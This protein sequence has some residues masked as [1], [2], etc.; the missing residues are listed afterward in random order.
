PFTERPRVH[1]R[2]GESETKHRPSCRIRRGFSQGIQVLGARRSYRSRMA[3]LHAGLVAASLTAPAHA[4]TIESS[5]EPVDQR[6]AF[7]GQ[8]TFVAQQTNAFHAPYAGPNSLKPSDREETFD[9]TLYAGLRVGTRTELWATPEIDQGFGLSDTLGVAGFPSGEAYKV[10]KSDPYFKLPR[11]F[12]RITF[13]VGGNPAR[14]ESGLMQLGGAQ[15][16]DRVVVTAG[17]FS[18]VDVFDAGRYAH[19]PRADFMN[20][21]AIDAGAFDYAADAWGFTIGA[22]AEWY[23]HEWTFR[24]G[25]F[26][27]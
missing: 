16:G 19:D 1:G 22:A 17:K 18:V 23:Q 24:G 25:W 21:T 2:R 7:N 27:L 26:V 20:W 3:P 6:H 4:E 10:G 9:A 11:A 14:V 13:D 8:A 5:P 15:T 12:A